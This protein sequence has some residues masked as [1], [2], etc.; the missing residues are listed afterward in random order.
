MVHA[1]RKLKHRCLALSLGLTGFFPQLVYGATYVID[2]Q[3]GLVIDGQSFTS[4]DGDCIS[5]TNSSNITISNASIVH[6]Y[7]VGVSIESSQNVTIRDSYF[8]D[9]N[10]GVYALNSSGIKV[11]YDKFKNVTR[12]G[13]LD[14]SRGQFVQFDK[15]SGA[16]NVVTYNR[17]IIEPGFEPEDLISMFETNGTA[18]SPVNVLGNC[19]Q[20]GGTSPS[21]GG[22]MSGDFGGSYISVRSNTLVNPG[23]YGLAVAG[24]S[25][26]TLTGNKVYAA[27]KAGNNIGLYVWAQGG[28][29]CSN[30]TVSSNQVDYHVEDGSENNAWDAGNCG[31]V[32]GWD[33]NNFNVDL[34]NLSCSLDT[35]PKVSISTPT[36]GSTV[37]PGS[38]VAIKAFASD[39]FG[40]TKVQFFVNDTLTCTDTVKPYT[41]NFTAS[42]TSGTVYSLKAKAFDTA[43]QTRL[44]GI[45]SV[46]VQ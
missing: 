25:H 42:T 12:V 23:Q 16:G 22:I 24:G 2:G 8:E 34:S 26:I 14:D 17:G 11:T 35:P 9:L 18:A 28:V 43:G 7:G 15:V 10:G 44:T 38:D 20:G 4:A 46:T 21:G 40:V 39:D 33:T 41:C 3:N 29:A 27:P 1:S 13:K 30:I 19:F 31:T 37:P 45:I 5:I 6:C 36:N 32:S